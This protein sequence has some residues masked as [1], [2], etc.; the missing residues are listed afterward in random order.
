MSVVQCTAQEFECNLNRP[1]LSSL[2]PR[3]MFVPRRTVW[4]RKF[5]SWGK[6]QDLDA[7]NQIAE[8]G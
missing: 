3:P 7:A 1:M 4:L 6:H 5:K 2:V 8:W